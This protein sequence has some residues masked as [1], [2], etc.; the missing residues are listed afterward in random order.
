[1]SCSMKSGRHNEAFFGNKLP[2]AGRTCKGLNRALIVLPHS[3]CS[4]GS[5]WTIIQK[6]SFEAYCL[7]QCAASKL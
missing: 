2:N 3:S 6:G 7:E 5:L 4:M 1:M